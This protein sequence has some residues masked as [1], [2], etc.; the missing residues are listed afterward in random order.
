MTKVG[1]VETRPLLSAEAS[2]AKDEQLRLNLAGGLPLYSSNPNVG[3]ATKFGIAALRST[4]AISFGLALCYGSFLLLQTNVEEGTETYKGYVELDLCSDMTSMPKIASSAGYDKNRW[5]DT[6][7]QS[8]RKIVQFIFSDETGSELLPRLHYYSSEEQ[9]VGGPARQRMLSLGTLQ[10]RPLIYDVAVKGPTTC[11]NDTAT[12]VD[13]FGYAVAHA[14]RSTSRRMPLTA[15]L[16]ST[17]TVN[18][19]LLLRGDTLQMWNDQ[20]SSFVTPYYVSFGWRAFYVAYNCSVL[21]FAFTIF[22]YSFMLVR[23][24]WTEAVDGWVVQYDYLWIKSDVASTV[25]GDLALQPV[26]SEADK[27]EYDWSKLTWRQ[28]M[29][30]VILRL[31]AVSV[32]FL[33]DELVGNPVENEE[34]LWK[35]VVSALLQGIM[36]PLTT[37]L[38]L[39]IG[40]FY[41]PVRT[42][43]WALIVVHIFLSLVYAVFYN[44]SAWDCGV[45]VLIPHLLVSF[46]IVVVSFWYLAAVLLFLTT[47][48]VAD[49][50]EVLALAVPLITI[51]LYVVVVVNQL[52]AYQQHL[53]DAAE[54]KATKG[55][56]QDGLTK[57]NLTTRDILVLIVST[58]LSLFAL[59]VIL[60]LAAA[61]HSD[62]STGSLGNPIPAI[63]LPLSSTVTAVKS[64][65]DAKNNLAK[66]IQE[67]QDVIQ[68]VT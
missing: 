38:V 52:M 60:L 25:H 5:L 61:L 40:V 20:L 33:L 41:P 67:A 65:L 10:V 13:R 49:P 50:S 28:Y 48:L 43:V 44:F 29:I 66:Q 64:I 9:Y 8:N 54:G 37:G 16:A 23:R 12:A 35:G 3:A 31:R 62:S 7:G 6:L 39:V 15:V 45:V 56:L 36:M 26:Q 22:Y 14:L 19:A 63:I 42:F 57:A 27:V 51:V 24:Q 47:R 4:L 21:V 55:F 2:S 46:V 11:L 58:T 18:G 59:L 68:K 32:Y 34:V 17:F 30:R 53:R 1:E